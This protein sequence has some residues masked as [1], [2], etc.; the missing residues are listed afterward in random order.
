MLTFFYYET[1]RVKFMK[2]KA[3]RIIKAILAFALGYIFCLQLYL[4]TDSTLNT[5]MN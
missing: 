4:L 1:E 2:E 3:L 5:H